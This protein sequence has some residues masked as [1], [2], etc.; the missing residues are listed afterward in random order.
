MPPGTPGVN[1]VCQISNMPSVSSVFHPGNPTCVMILLPG[2][3]ALVSGA[4]SKSPFTRILVGGN[5]A[6]V[7]SSKFPNLSP[8]NIPLNRLNIMQMDK[9][10]LSVVLCF[11][12]IE[13]PHMAGFQIELG[14]LLFM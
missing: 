1:P 11:F 3:F 2:V 13:S 4:C 7:T 10:D 12:F 9:I 6:A 5:V 8:V 14:S